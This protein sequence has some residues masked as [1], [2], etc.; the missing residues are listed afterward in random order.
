MQTISTN[1]IE[2]LF[3]DVL[4]SLSDKEKKVIERRI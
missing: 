3:F 1:K 4:T 2:N